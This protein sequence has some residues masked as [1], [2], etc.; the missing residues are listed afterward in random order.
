MS[1][2][3][4]SPARSRRWTTRTSS[5]STRPARPTAC[6]TSRCGSWPAA[7]CT[8]SS[9]GRDRCAGDRAVTLLSPIASA[10]DAAH[11]A[12]LVHRDVK[13]ANILVDRGP[14]RPEHPYLSDFGLAKGSA[15]STGLTG[16]G[17]FL[18]TP[19]YAAPEQISGKP[20]RPQTD[21][22]ALACVAVHGPHRLAAVRPRRVHGRALGA[23]VR[24]AA[25]AHRRPPRPATGRPTGSWPAP[26]PSPRRTA[27]RPAPTSS[28][29]CGQRSACPRTGRPPPTRHPLARPAGRNIL[30]AAPGHGPRTPRP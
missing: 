8:R 22:Y 19:D 28:T 7:T 23:H 13:P 14:G 4:G 24:P 11:A 17:Q 26:W 2:S 10:L 5:P 30:T 16:T 20:A 27:T 29:R 1:G 9:S 3:S 18:G 12:G 6:S 15:A 25:P 21:Q